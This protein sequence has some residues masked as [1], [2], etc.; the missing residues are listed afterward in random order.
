MDFSRSLVKLG[1]LPRVS[2]RD[3]QLPRVLLIVADNRIA[4]GVVG[5]CLF[6]NCCAS[7]ILQASLREHTYAQV[8]G[9]A[10]RDRIARA[11]LTN[12]AA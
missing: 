5:R 11:D 10:G 4:G 12:Q 1:M 9:E 7:A 3:R 8:L 2:E 6:W